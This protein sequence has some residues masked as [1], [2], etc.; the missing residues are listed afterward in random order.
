M[1]EKCLLKSCAC[2]RRFKVRENIAAT[3]IL[4]GQYAE[5][6]QAYE[7]IM[8][9]R[10]NYR[11]GF[12]LLLCYHALS[13]R[14]KTRRAFSDLLKIP[15]ISSDEDYQPAV[16]L[17]KE[18]FLHLVDIA[19]VYFIQADKGDK[20]ANLVLE[21]TRDDR[22]R[23]F[24]RKRYRRLVVFPRPFSILLFDRR[25]R[26]AEHVIVTAAKIV[27]NNS[28]GDFVSGY[29]WCIEQVRNSTYLELASGLEIQKAIAYLR[30]DNFP[31]VIRSIR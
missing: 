28:D 19:S 27:G 13:Q 18:N 17:H 8:Q 31:K 22:L 7:A 20:Q 2:H 10:P 9:E 4:M 23:Q 15:F 6:A 1:N 24:E 12:N 16:S 21:A 30:E 25:R 5:A 26:F 29:E 11:S 14:D 3:H